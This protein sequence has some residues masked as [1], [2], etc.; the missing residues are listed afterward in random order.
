VSVASISA[1]FALP[2]ATW[3][4]THDLGLTLVMAVLGALAIFKHRRNIQRLLDGTE[5]RFQF[6]KREA[7]P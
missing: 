6:K 5:N 7:A 3:F 2:F 1:S 4:T